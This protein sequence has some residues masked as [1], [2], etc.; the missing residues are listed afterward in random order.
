M[1]GC[2]GGRFA[3]RQQ[4][5]SK[6]RRNWAGLRQKWKLLGLFEI[7]QQHEFYP[8]TS[9]MKEGLAT[10]AQ[11]P[12]DQDAPTELSDDD[13]RSEV[14]QTHEDF[15]MK[16]FAGPVFASLRG[17]LGM[18]QQDYRQSLCSEN[19]YLQFISNSKSKAD[20]FLTNDKR[21]FLKTQNEREVRFLLDNL[22]NYVEHLRNYP[23]SLL[24]K[25]LGVH[26][27]VIP[28]RW[29]KYFIVMLSVFYPDDRISARYDIKGCEVSRWTQPA[30]EGSGHVVVL[31]DLNFEGQYITLAQQRSWLL[32]QVDID[33]RFLQR[34]NVLDYSF[35]LAQQPLQPDE[36][37]QVLSLRTLII[38][39][40]RSVN[41]GSSFTYAG[42][43]PAD[44]PQH[45]STSASPETDL[46]KASE[47]AGGSSVGGGLHPGPGPGPGPDFRAQNRRLLPD[48]K[49]PLHVIDGPEQRYFM[50]I[51]DIF[52][53]YTFRKRLEHWW[54]RLRHPG[55]S[56]STVSP[57]TYCL[58]LCDWLRDHTK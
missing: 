53:V 32:L 16:T 33:T 45:E 23:H 57:Q 39:T 36:Q 44:G 43:A 51:I 10:A 12:P 58:R 25:F 55:R 28:H 14:T 17:S 5:G 35:L 4:A 37:L 27:I 49:N 34:L 22:K 7:D 24:V 19:C 41:P 2:A 40:K 48:L 47:A 31:K 11:N 21:F 18:T 20:F 29:K 38:R 6:K 13:Y 46:L 56:F 30:P 3:P 1:S 15:T 9:M 54:K 50:G 42:R 8:L 26:R 52:T